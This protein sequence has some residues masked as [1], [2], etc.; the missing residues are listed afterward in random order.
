MTLVDTNLLIFAMVAPDRL[1][2]ACRERLLRTEE[3]LCFSHASVWEVSVKFSLKRPDFDLN[4]RKFYSTLL[5]MGLI[6]LAIAPAHLFALLR[7][8]PI[9]RDP[10][11]RLLVAQA[12]HEKATLLTTDTA[13]AQYGKRVVVTR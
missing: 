7:L 1:S 10:F 4:P 2:E 13:L 9:H 3:T 8:P 12:S 5:K 6:E 11:D